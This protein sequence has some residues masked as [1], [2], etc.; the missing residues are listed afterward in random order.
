MAIVV[1]QH[2][3]AQHVLTR[4]R[5]RTTPPEQFRRLASQAALLLAMEAARDLAATEHPVE[6]PIETTTGTTAQGISVVAI[7]RAGLGLAQ[8]MA[9][10]LPGATLGFLGLERDE[11][12]ALARAYY[13][14]LPPLSG[15][16]VLLVDPMLATGGSAIQAMGALPEAARPSVRFVCVVAA[17]EGVAALEAA[18]PQLTIVTLALDRC[19]NERKYIVPGLGDF[20]DRLFGTL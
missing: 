15:R 20:G 12:T 6:T 4:L 17:P 11:R 1:V 5:D 10:F 8:P 9:D 7:L 18:F 2:A 13:A 19:L 3:L 16:R 14:K